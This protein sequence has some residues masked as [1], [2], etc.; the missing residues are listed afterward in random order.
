MGIG[1]CKQQ[2]AAYS[3]TSAT[4]LWNDANLRYRIKQQHAT[5]IS[6][7]TK[8]GLYSRTRPGPG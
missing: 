2:W 4:L 3:L 6:S 8:Q 7:V 5:Y 1:K